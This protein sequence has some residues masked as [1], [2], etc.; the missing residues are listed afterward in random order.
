MKDYSTPILQPRGWRKSLRIGLLVLVAGLFLAPTLWMISSSLKPDYEIFA[1]PPSLLPIS[2]R[3]QNYAEALT[4]LPFGRF[5]INTL[6]I[7]LSTIVGHLLS[8]SIVAYGF[9]RLNGPGKGFFFVLM[10]STLMLPYPV[11]MVPLFIIFSKIGLINSFV[12]LILPAFFGNAFYIFLLRQSFKQIPVDL[13]DAARLDGA[14]T[15]QVLANVILPLSRPALATVAI[16]TFQAAWNDFLG[17]LIFLHD[18]SLYTLQLGL[19]LFRGAYNVQWA[20]LMAASLV[21]TLPVIAIFFIAQ[22]SFIEGVGFT[23]SKL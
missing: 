23:G 9:A 2:P 16:F 13:E 4:S 3:W 10:L 11:T 7:A 19:S 18:Q 8:C 21:V 12:P 15:L 6:I 20:Y 5:A 22:K 14:G 17:P 1:T